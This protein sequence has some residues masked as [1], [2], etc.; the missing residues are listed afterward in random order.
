MYKEI[1]YQRE[2]IQQ[3]E[4]TYRRLLDKDHNHEEE[5]EVLF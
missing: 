5:D 3:L 4:D 1:D 2:R